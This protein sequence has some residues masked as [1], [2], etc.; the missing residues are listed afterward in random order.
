MAGWKLLGGLFVIGVLSFS[1]TVLEAAA[2]AERIGAM[3]LPAASDGLKQ[4]V[5]EKG[6]RVTLDGGWTAEFWFAKQLKTAA[7]VIF[8][9]ASLG[10]VE[11]MDFCGA[12]H[13]APLDVATAKNFVPLNIRFQPYRLSKSRCWGRPDLRITCVACHDPHEPLVHDAAFYDAKCLAC[14]AAAATEASAGVAADPVHGKHSSCPVSTIRCVS[15]HMPKY[16]D[17]QFHGSFTDH[18][19]RIV[20]PG[21]A[22]PL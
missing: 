12:C 6:Y 10:P 2:Q 20:H 19:I 5:E 16:E 3:T 8:N 4:S 11:L 22:Y 7:E 15:C 13:R 1:P 21:D 17:P 9:P 14:H 18:D